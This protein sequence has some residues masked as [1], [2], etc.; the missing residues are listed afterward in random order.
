M[1]I[2]GKRIQKFQ[3]YKIIGQ[4]TYNLVYADTEKNI[5]MVNIPLEYGGKLATS[6]GD[7]LG[8]GTR[9]KRRQVSFKQLP[10]DVKKQV[11]I[12]VD[13]IQEYGSP[14]Q[15]DQHIYQN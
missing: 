3:T 11:V 4:K 15:N 8:D 14:M 6:L 2:N 1:I 7:H 13:Y 5:K 10:V 9:I 12:A